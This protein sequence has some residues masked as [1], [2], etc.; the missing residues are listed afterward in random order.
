VTPGLVSRRLWAF[1]AGSALTDLALG[2][3]QLVLP[4]LVY[5][6]TRSALWLGVTAA[7]QTLVPWGLPVYGV[8]V[9]R[10]DRR[11]L[12]ILALLV[13]ALAGGALAVLAG[14]GAPSLA[15]V[16]LLAALMAVGARMQLLAGSTV[17]RVLT[18]ER[19]RVSYNSWWANGSLLATYAAP[20]SAG[21]LLAWMG[22][23]RTL[24]LLS[25]LLL[26][27]LVVAV[28]LPPVP[29]GE[30]APQSVARQFQSAWQMLRAERPLYLFTLVFAWWN[31]T[32]S[33]A[34]AVM[35]YFYRATL[36]FSAAD[37]GLVGV[38]AAVIPLTLSVSGPWWL[39]KMETGRLLVGALLLS[40]LSFLVMPA[41]SLPWTVGTVL[42]AADGPIGPILAALSTMSQARI[43]GGW[44]GR[45]SSVRQFVT[46]ALVPMVSL[47]AGACATRFGAPAVLMTVGALMAAGVPVA[48][49]AG[50]GRIT[51]TGGFAPGS[52]MI[53]GK[54]PAPAAISET[55]GDG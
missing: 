22:P 40:G 37:V 34:M 38:T 50:A 27:A 20:G 31:W 23:A 14:M 10:F 51:L 42:G 2:W 33:G 30:S 7:V 19:A 8:L 49:R 32:W 43:P 24:G 29:G 16:L 47:A 54:A 48:W 4:W 36:H 35:V 12:L 6:V 1:L 52:A 13:Q 15:A 39:R 55:R 21:F 25:L 44:Y 5:D 46:A 26:P 53:Q 45:V 3:Y 18:P 17:R 41:L 11:R 9:D 28:R